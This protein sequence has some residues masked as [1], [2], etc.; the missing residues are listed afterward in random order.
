M[1]LL[2]HKLPLL[3]T[4]PKP[5]SQV[6]KQY[7]PNWP[8]F[9]EQHKQCPRHLAKFLDPFFGDKKKKMESVLLLYIGLKFPFW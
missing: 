4:S 9:R 3:S 1:R 2:D 8:F 7:Q 6:Y 5:F